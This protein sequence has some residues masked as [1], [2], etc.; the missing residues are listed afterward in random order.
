VVA[1]LGGAGS[2]CGVTVAGPQGGAGAVLRSGDAVAAG[3]APV[4]ATEPSGPG[5][6]EAKW[7]IIII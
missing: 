4:P 7:Q 1:G 6:R 3:G 2:V 5:G